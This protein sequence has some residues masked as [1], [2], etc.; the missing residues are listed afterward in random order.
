MPEKGSVRITVLAETVQL[1]SRLRG[2]VAL[3]SEQG[4]GTRVM[5]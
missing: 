3:R 1:A 5:V 2:G 4:P